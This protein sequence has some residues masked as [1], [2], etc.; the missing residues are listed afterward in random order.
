MENKVSIVALA[1]PAAD[2][3]TL[4]INGQLICCVLFAA[5]FAALCSDQYYYC[6]ATT[7]SLLRSHASIAS[8]DLIVGNLHLR[9]QKIS[10]MSI[11]KNLALRN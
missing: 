10:L 5:L 8:V 2:V 6:I 9:S 3:A 1:A 4:Q 7:S 11:K